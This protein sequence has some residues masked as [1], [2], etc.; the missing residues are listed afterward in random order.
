MINK[1]TLSEIL[2]IKIIEVSPSIYKDKIYYK[3]KN[4][5]K[6][7]FEEIRYINIYKLVHQGKVWALKNKYVIDE[8]DNYIEVIGTMERVMTGRSFSDD[9]F[10]S[11]SNSR[12]L[13]VLNWIYSKLEESDDLRI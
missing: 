2:N 13:N 7:F 10:S 11:F 4:Y 12:M 8:S 5:E 1:E 3:V 6:S 9:K